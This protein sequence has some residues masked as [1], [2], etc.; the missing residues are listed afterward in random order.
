M[1]AVENKDSG[2]HYGVAIELDDRCDASS[3]ASK[4]NEWIASVNVDKTKIAMFTSDGAAV[5]LGKISD[6]RH[7]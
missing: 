5:M 4:I 6:T 1:V 2:E 7:R 3:I